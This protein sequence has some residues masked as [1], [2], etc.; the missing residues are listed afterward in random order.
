MKDSIELRFPANEAYICLARYAAAAFANNYGFDVERIE[1]IKLVVGEACNNAVLYGDNK[2]NDIELSLSFRKSVMIIEIR[3]QGFGFNPS[4][5]NEPIIGQTEEG[6][7]GIYIMKTLA[8][9][10][11]V[12]SAEGDGTTL[13]IEFALK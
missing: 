1:D 4:N 11:E 8:D 3:D 6:G 12:K 10:L 7:F 13:I 5:C 9:K 2:L